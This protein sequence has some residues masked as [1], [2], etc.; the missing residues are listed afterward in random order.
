[1]KN[2]V[3]TEKTDTTKRTPPGKECVPK[4][5]KFT[6]GMEDDDVKIVF[7]IEMFT[8]EQDTP[9]V[10]SK[11][12]MHQDSMLSDHSLHTAEKR[13]LDLF[14]TGIA[15]QF[16]QNL[17]NYINSKVREFGKRSQASSEPLQLEDGD[18]RDT[19]EG[20]DPLESL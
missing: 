19:F 5:P 7:T 4:E 6:D 13:I 14:D 1:M 17:A 10:K 15:T 18:F 12:L 11:G 20:S 3:S 16:K 9:V 8:G 2:S